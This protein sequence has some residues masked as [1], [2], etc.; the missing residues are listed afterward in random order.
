M[1]NTLDVPMFNVRKRASKKAG[2]LKS[3]CDLC[4]SSSENMLCATSYDGSLEDYDYQKIDPNRTKLYFC[5]L[6]CA[7]LY[8]VNVC[9]LTIDVKTYRKNYLDGMLNNTSNIIYQK[10]KS[11]LFTQLPIKV[12]T[13]PIGTPKE[14]KEQYRKIKNTY[15]NCI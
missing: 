8:D 12:I 4:T 3:C 13:K 9:K 6:I 14:I 5:D 2:K 10:C 1:T 15:L 7:K 11:V